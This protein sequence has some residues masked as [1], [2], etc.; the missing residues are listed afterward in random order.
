M[1]IVK[2]ANCGKEVFVCPGVI[3][4]KC[5]HCGKSLWE[6]EQSNVKYDHRNC[7][8]KWVREDDTTQMEPRSWSCPFC[9]STKIL[10]RSVYHYFDYAGNEYTYTPLPG[11]G[12]MAIKHVEK[13]LEKLR[14][15]KK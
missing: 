7:Q 3:V 6:K 8:H 2:C 14:K 4:K 15:K 5:E 11:E 12:E 13:E 9:H 1:S 10:I